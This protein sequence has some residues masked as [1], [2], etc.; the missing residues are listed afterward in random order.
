MFV[1]AYATDEPNTWDIKILDTFL[2]VIEQVQTPDDP[3][4]FTDSFGYSTELD[5]GSLEEALLELSLQYTYTT[6]H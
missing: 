3:F 1:R 4:I 5:V 2:G 6:K